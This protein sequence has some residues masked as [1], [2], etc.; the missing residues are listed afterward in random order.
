MRT[1]TAFVSVVLALAIACGPPPKPGIPSSDEIALTIERAGYTNAKILA[2]DKDKGLV[3]A[4]AERKG[5]KALIAATSS[6]VIELAGSPADG[7]VVRV[8]DYAGRDDLAKVTVID[9]TE[10]THYVVRRADLELACT[11]E[12]DF[13]AGIATYDIPHSGACVAKGGGGGGDGDVV[14]DK[15]KDIYTKAVDAYNEANAAGWTKDRCGAVATTFADIAKKFDELPLARFMAGRAHENCGDDKNARAQYELALRSNPRHARALSNLGGIAFRAGDTAEAKKL[16]QKA[17]D[18]NSK[19]LAARNNLAWLLIVELRST[20]NQTKWDDLEEAAKNHLSSVLA[21]DNE[22]VKA[23]VLYGLLFM[24][25]YEKN[26]SR[27]DLAN[28]LLDEAKKRN[29]EYAPLYNARGLYHLHKNNLGEALKQFSRA[30]ELD[31]LFIEARMNVGLITL[32]FRKYDAAAE[33]FS[34]VLKVQPKNY[35][36]HIGVGIAVR[37]QG[38]HED[39]EASYRKALEIAPERG[40]ALFNLGVL[41]KDFYANA[42]D[43]LKASRESYKEAR[44]LFEQFIAK[45]NITAADKKE[46]EANLA[47]CDK[48][49]PQLAEVIKAMEADAASGGDGGTTP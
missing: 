45:P 17:I 27:L 3:V 15:A 46:A 41:Y 38:K 43:D 26:R 48:I 44:K 40:E 2:Y 25:G 4:V 39:A 1:T 37:G 29:A 22:N 14:P 32:G 36:A 13:K 28:L 30:V 35:D 42:K 34:A 21:V 20:T 31:P 24:E 23:Y 11:V 8:G 16:W 5:Q 19:L 7:I 18:E 10:E 9:G 49:I 6:K 33:Q 12:G 47:D